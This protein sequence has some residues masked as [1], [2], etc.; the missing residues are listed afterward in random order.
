MLQFLERKYKREK[1]FTEEKKGQNR[2]GPAA[3]FLLSLFL[4][5]RGPAAAQPISPLSRLPPKTEKLL[6]VPSL[7]VNPSEPARRCTPHSFPGEGIRLPDALSLS[8]ILI[9]SLPVVLSL[10]RLFPARARAR[11]HG[12]RFSPP[13]SA[14]PPAEEHARGSAVAPSSSLPQNRA[15]PRPKSPLPVAVS[16]QV[17]GAHRRRFAAV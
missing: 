12:R 16:P 13:L 15:A 8:L 10:S 2:I 14:S 9:P 7:A 5:Q 1:G 11:R 17:S 4:F 6:A 3:Q